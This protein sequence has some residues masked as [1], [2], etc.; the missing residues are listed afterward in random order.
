MYRKV[1]LNFTN[2]S[3]IQY[4]FTAPRHRKN[5]GIQYNEG[6][7]EMTSPLGQGFGA[8]IHYEHYFK[9]ID[10]SALWGAPEIVYDLDQ[11]GKI[12]NYESYTYLSSLELAKDNRNGFIYEENTIPMQAPEWYLYTTAHVRNNFFLHKKNTLFQNLDLRQEFAAI[13]DKN[14]NPTQV[15]SRNT[16]GKKSVSIT[17]PAHT[18]FPDMAVKNMLTQEAQKVM[19]DLPV[20]TSLPLELSAQSGRVVASSATAWS[21]QFGNL[22][23][24]WLPEGEFS[25]KADMDGSG[26]PLSGMTPVFL[27][28]Q[29]SVPQ[30]NWINTRRISRYDDYGRATE[31][32]NSPINTQ[33]KHADNAV[34]GHR[35]L[36]KIGLL[37]NAGYRESGIYTSDYDDNTNGY[38]DM[39]NGWEQGAGAG[40]VS[41]NA[42]NAIFGD[43][44]LKVV[45]AF[46]PS[47]DT[48]LIHGKEYLF[49]AWVKVES[50]VLDLAGDF[51][52][53]KNQ[54]AVDEDAIWPINY[55]HLEPPDNAA[56]PPF[57]KTIAAKSPAVWERIEVR[58]KTDNLTAVGKWYARHFVGTPGGGTA[59]IQDVR[60]HPVDASAASTYYGFP[61]VL[62]KVSLDENGNPSRKSDYDGFGRARNSYKMKVENG[63]YSGDVLA[64]SRS[65]KLVQGI[66][67]GQHIQILYPIGGET[68]NGGSE[69]NI[70]WRNDETRNI[71]IAFTRDNGSTWTDITNGVSVMSGDYFGNFRWNAPS[72]ADCSTCRIMLK[73]HANPLIWTGSSNFTISSPIHVSSPNGGEHI[74]GGDLVFITYSI[75]ESKADR[76]RVQYW[77]GVAWVLIASVSSD[78]AQ[79]E[80]TEWRVP[81][82]FLDWSEN[83]GYRDQWQRC[84]R[85][86]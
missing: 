10:N 40:T 67:D 54:Y 57:G 30:N 64:N 23:G 1:T 35:G 19:L 7:R 36:Y 39:A 47:R 86:R 6:P 46:G 45:D 85:V 62:P 9:Y 77:N 15:S 75:D 58:F 83:P 74:N 4:L 20:S 56:F 11:S 71:D 70:R 73:D 41:L 68:I 12:I 31:F 55:N 72:G 34:F 69:V 43:K 59:Y 61:L 50:G 24:R 26:L 37:K 14:G 25:W 84:W 13:D 33:L 28:N 38:L 32:I 5:L 48:R 3:K 44:C 63:V 21:N 8:T 80:N 16:D 49:S 2:D 53:L 29:C 27:C 42:G 81:E 18:V 52:R 22:P 78:G 82:Y 17:I 51:R 60:I 66:P 79:W 65:Y 76:A